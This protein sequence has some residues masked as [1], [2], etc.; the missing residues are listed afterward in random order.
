MPW[1]DAARRVQSLMPGP[2]QAAV[3]RTFRSLRAL[4]NRG[5]AVWCPLCE[6]SFA[7]FV[8]PRGAS[9]PSCDSRERH[10]LLWLYLQHET[11]VFRAPKRLL[12]FA[13]EDRSQRVLRSLPNLDYVSADLSSRTAMV[14]T[15]IT[16]LDFP[17]E[18]FDVILCS[19]VLEHVP[20]DARAMREL[21]RVLKRGGVAI[22]QVPVDHDRAETYEDWS[23]TTGEERAKAFGQR[24]HVRWYGR[25]FAQRLANAGFQVTAI[26]YAQQHDAKRLGLDANEEIFRCEK[27]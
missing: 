18:S 21:H 24:D 22:V 11:D 13:P 2:L 14:N 12:H 25:D 8:N 1:I 23:L 4:A 10:R 17:D 3:L 26:R 7:R 27:R 15:D 16:Q 5:G 9:C 19:H 6:R 20:D